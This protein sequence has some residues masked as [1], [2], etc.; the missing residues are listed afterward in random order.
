[1]D[2]G[3]SGP[4]FL[5]IGFRNCDNFVAR[6]LLRHVLSGFETSLSHSAAQFKKSAGVV[7]FKLPVMGLHRRSGVPLQIFL[8]LPSIAPAVHMDTNAHVL[9]CTA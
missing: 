3:I 8:P 9:K 6:S 1:M 2:T 4:F 7:A 5:N